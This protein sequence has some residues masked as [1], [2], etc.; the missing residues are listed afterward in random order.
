MSVEP[1]P[2]RWQSGATATGASAKAG[3]DSANSNWAEGDM[4]DHTI[5]DEG[6]N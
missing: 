5:F 6:D 3:F 4:P 2:C 1:M